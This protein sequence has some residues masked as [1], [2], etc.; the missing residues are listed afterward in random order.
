[1]LINSS[2]QVGIGTSTPYEQLVVPG[3]TPTTATGSIATGTQ[4]A[5]IYVQGRYAYVVNGGSNSL[6]IFDTSNSASPVSVGSVATGSVPISVYVQGRYAYVL[7]NTGNT[8]QVF[9][10]SNP[11]SPASVGSV[12]TGA[13]TNPQ[14]VYVQGRYA[15]V[16]QCQLKHLANI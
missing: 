1:M 5:S 9:D 10:V 8:L 12:A 6:Q 13:G 3:K 14:S 15:Y 16:S 4:P 11:A 2:G 7:N